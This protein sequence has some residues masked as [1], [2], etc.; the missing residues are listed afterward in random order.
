M[1]VHGAKGLQAPVVILPDTTMLPKE[2]D[3]ILWGTDPITQ[4]PVPL[5]SPG[6]A[7]RCA[8]LDAL[9][10]RDRQDAMEEYNRLLYVALTRAEDRLLVC[11]WAGRS[12]PHER[13]WYGAVA[14]GFQRLSPEESPFGRGW[15][16]AVLR[17]RSAQTVPADRDGVD[18]TSAPAAVLPS[19][20]GRAPDWRMGPP[21]PE[22]PR[23][24][25]LAPSR[26][27]GV[28]L[29]EV[30]AAA[31][32]LGE[33]VRAPDRFRRGQVIHALLQH[34]PELPASDQAEAATRYLARSGVGIDVAD[35]AAIVAEVI[36]IMEHADLAPLF[37]PAGR[38]EVPLTGVIGQTV[39][40]GLVDRLV[41][42]PDRVL[43][44][45]F[46]TNRHTPNRVEET[47]VL[48]LRQM[49]IYRAVLRS[50]FPDR[51]VRC[52]LIWTRAGRVSVLPDEILDRHAPERDTGGD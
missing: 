20:L 5:L 29:G 24:V 33:G 43:L 16:G 49:A 32:P 13:S 41:V 17:I 28:D 7:F 21:P 39:V 46:K 22:P 15:D 44:A 19:W 27:E 30:P 40:G 36:G 1:T 38:A 12:E 9:R 2:G 35:H 25:P 47:P 51:P 34:L 23:P 3:A 10:D 48:Y 45:D 4:T 42:L 6:K 8:T 52:A 31:S 37:G 50:V 11:G 14:R 26:P 18:S